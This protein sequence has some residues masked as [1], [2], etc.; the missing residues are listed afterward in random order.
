MKKTILILLALIS[1]NVY[2]NEI[3]N[4]AD[5]DGLS[6]TLEI[7]IG[8]DPAVADQT[9][10]F[11]GNNFVIHKEYP[12]GSGGP[13]NIQFPLN[14]F[15]QYFP[16][17]DSDETNGEY[18]HSG[19]FH[20][21]TQET[22]TFRCSGFHTNF[23]YT[24]SGQWWTLELFLFYED[25]THHTFGRPPG[26]T[27]TMQF[28]NPYPEKR[29][30]AITYIGQG[31]ATRNGNVSNFTIPKYIA[32][33]SQDSDDD[34]LSDEDEVNI[35][36]TDPNDADSDDDGLSDGDEVNIHSTDPNDSDSDDDGISDGD[37]VTNGI[38]PLTPNIKPELNLDI[39][40]EAQS[41]Q[42]ILIDATPTDGYP[43]NFTYQW[44]QNGYP[45]PSLFGGTEITYS[46]LGDSSYNGNWSVIVGNSVGSVTNSFVFEVFVD[47]DLD[48]LSN[49]RETYVTFTNPNNS[50][51]DDDNLGD[52]YEVNTSI[53]NP[54]D[55]DSDDD[56]LSDG[57]EVHASSTNPN[58]SDSDGDGLSDGYEVNT[59]ASDP[60][61]ADSDDDGL[62]DAYE[63]YSSVS[64]PN[65]ADSDD[66]SL[67]DAYEVYTSNTDPND[68][69]SDDDGL[70]DGYEV[71]TSVSDPNDAD[72]DD[73]GFN[74]ASEITLGLNPNLSNEN[75]INFIK[76]NPSIF[77]LIEGGMTMSEAQ[78]AMRD[79]RLG[80]QTFGVS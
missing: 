79:L 51:S 80:S 3:Y 70:S 13:H 12:N 30:I 2:A 42:T 57:Y 37:E 10:G 61:D 66:D 26:G 21:F 48:S 15:E 25:G 22:L 45:I 35:H 47:N 29:I 36:S 39:F 18:I 59:S 1:Q 44:S 33:E 72:S 9:E 46:F 41:G 75:V 40:Y 65:D 23:Q 64:D 20:L 77:N 56:G 38:S 67:G 53:T 71:N 54:N 69:D 5:G 31:T 58:G 76:N 4:D 28:V 74:D 17:N 27:G 24:Y 8:G 11:S 32:Q 68:S 52:G 14:E 34:G 7:F 63:V 60:N 6:E 49:G 16:E 55:S 50:D 78:A 73:D 62:D 19:N 43:T